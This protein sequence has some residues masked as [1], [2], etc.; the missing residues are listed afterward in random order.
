M[1]FQQAVRC[2]ATGL[3]VYSTRGHQYVE[4]KYEGDTPHV[5]QA[6]SPDLRLV[7]FEVAGAKTVYGYSSRAGKCGL[8]Q[9]SFDEIA[10]KVSWVPMEGTIGS[11]AEPGV[12]IGLWGMDRDKLLISRAEDRAGSLAIHWVTPVVQ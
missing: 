5:Y 7:G 8:Y 11:C 10:R 1:N 12:I 3:V 2:S 6:Q 9:L 4:M